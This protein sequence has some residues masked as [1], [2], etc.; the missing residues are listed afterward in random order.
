[1]PPPSCVAL[2]PACASTPTCACLGPAVCG[3]FAGSACD[4]S[5]GGPVLGCLS[6]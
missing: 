2:P 6:A 4:E 3:P 1:L 5:K